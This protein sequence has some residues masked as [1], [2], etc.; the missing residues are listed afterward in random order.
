MIAKL[1]TGLVFGLI[2][3][4]GC[5]SWAA[6]AQEAD[7]HGLQ[8][9]GMTL[10]DTRLGDGFCETGMAETVRPQCAQSESGWSHDSTVT[11]ILLD[12]KRAQSFFRLEG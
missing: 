8:I 5:A 9:Y 12:L 11:T 10:D 7:S 1:R 6:F 4:I 3:F 2:G